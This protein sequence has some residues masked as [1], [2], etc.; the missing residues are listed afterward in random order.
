VH[1]EKK[2][3]LLRFGMVTFARRNEAILTLKYDK[4]SR[5]VTMTGAGT[6]EANEQQILDMGL[7]VTGELRLITDAEVI[8]HNA[9]FVRDLPARGPGKKMYVWKID[10]VKSATPNLIL[11]PG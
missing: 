1:W 2:G 5:Q 9:S 8:Q 7:N 11:I 4:N 10:S 6:S 3:D